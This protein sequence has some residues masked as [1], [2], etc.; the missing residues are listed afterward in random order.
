M[1]VAV[2]IR[3]KRGGGPDRLRDGRS[4]RQ[5]W[6]RRSR[7]CDRRWCCD[8]WTRRAG[9]SPPRGPSISRSCGGAIPVISGLGRAAGRCMPPRQ[10]P[11]SYTPPMSRPWRPGHERSGAAYRRSAL[12]RATGGSP[13]SRTAARGA[14]WNDGR[15]TTPRTAPAK[16]ARGGTARPGRPRARRSANAVEDAGRLDS[17]FCPSCRRQCGY[18]AEVRRCAEAASL[19]PKARSENGVAYLYGGVLQAV[20][21]GGGH[22]RTVTLH[23]RT[24]TLDTAERAVVELDPGWRIALLEVKSRTQTSPSPADGW[25]AYYGLD[26]SNS[27]NLR[28][29]SGSGVIGR[30]VPGA[31]ALTRLN[32]LPAQTAP[33]TGADPSGHRPSMTAEGPS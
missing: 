31:R 1:P 28:H 8:S 20:L 29:L 19:S 2:L 3:S 17:Q 16:T 4:R 21:D 22:G 9:W 12:G 33:G 32:V 11:T 27:A 13:A 6:R 24:V 25:S 23:G 26:L 18:W 10:A 30:R 14:G 15:R 5:G 7:P